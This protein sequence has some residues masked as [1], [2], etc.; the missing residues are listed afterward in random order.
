M[1]IGF[2]SKRLFFNNS[3]L[4][5]YARFHSEIMR[6][7]DQFEPIWLSEKTAKYRNVRAT[8]PPFKWPGFRSWGMGRWA[9]KN[10][11][12]LYHGLSN[13][14]PLDWP[15][16]KP[17]VVTIHDT[18]FLD[19]PDY[20]NR[21]DRIIY[22]R[23]L[24][25]A[26]KRASE[27][28]ATSE[29]TRQS[30]LNHFPER[31]DIQVIYQGLNQDFLDAA[32][33]AKTITRDNPY[34]VYHSTF[35]ARKNHRTLLQAFSLIWKQC[36]W[37]LVLIGRPGSELD[38]LRSQV[39]SKTWGHRI[40][41]IVDA[42]DLALLTW[43]KG[44]SGFVYPSFSEGFG[45]PLIEAQFLGLPIVASRIPVF[46]ELLEEGALYFHP[47]SAEEMAASMMELQR[48]ETRSN[49]ISAARK[50]AHKW[51]PERLKS[52]WQSM[53]TRCLTTNP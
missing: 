31:T 35:N 46:Q 14:L 2:D 30:L 38:A 12:D 5:N 50:V 21:W 48:Q 9:L 52:Q 13:E 44:A 34:F 10:Q 45:I 23:K 6:D 22:K 3:G 20:Y 33:K 18:I 8:V 39:E 42:N 11:V 49:L 36:D 16:N 43:L 47:N 25:S 41:F 4:G 15:S 27:I 1:R 29:F 51:D 19:Y 7:L 28:V 53:Y 37:D 40:Q 17:S 26:M 32:S 24:Q